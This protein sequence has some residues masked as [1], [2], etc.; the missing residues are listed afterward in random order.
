[1]LKHYSRTLFHYETDADGV[2][3]FSNYFR[4]GEEAFYHAIGQSFSDMN[5]AV[6]ESHAQYK[7][8]LRF[9]SVF[10]V[11]IQKIEMR[12]SNFELSLLIEEKGLEVASLK[13]R[14]VAMD[15]KKWEIIPLSQEL[16]QRLKEYD[17]RPNLSFI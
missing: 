5:F 13:I 2:C 1:M 14:F 9:G 3:H 12:P 17:T 8:P 10:S 11:S 4:I 16:K 6:I 15:A 7:N